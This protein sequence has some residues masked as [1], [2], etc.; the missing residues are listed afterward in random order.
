MS[1]DIK[2]LKPL[3]L[4]SAIVVGLLLHNSCE[5]FAVIVP[6]LVFVMLLLTFNST[7]LRRLRFKRLDLWLMAFQSIASVMLY[8]IFRLAFENITVA[9]GMML[10]ALCPVAGSVTVV[11]VELGAKRSNTVA[12]TIVGNLLVSVLAPLMLAFIG[13]NHDMGFSDSFFSIF[14]KIAATIGLPFFVALVLQIWVKPVAKTL[15][16]YSGL[17]FYIWAMALLLTL[18]QTIDFIFIHGAGNWNV[19]ITLGIGS[20]FVCLI[21]FYIGRR[22]GTRFKDPVA[23]QQLLFQKNGA[24]GIWMSNTY[25]NPL[26]ST[27]LAFYIVEQNLTNSFQIWRHERKERKVAN[28]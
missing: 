13:N 16:R 23:G 26:A 9:Q 5:S 3:V 11:A 17:S 27:F 12:Y 7:E 6:Y 22:I 25:L 18:G 21:Q 14:G 10:G 20:V 2:R 4:P 1:I 8:V 15:T 19:I 28:V 24:V